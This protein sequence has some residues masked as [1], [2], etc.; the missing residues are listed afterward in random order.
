M[1]NYV[2]KRY[3]EFKLWLGTL[4]NRLTF[5]MIKR[6]YRPFPTFRAYVRYSNDPTHSGRMDM[7]ETYKNGLDS[8]KTPSELRDITRR[9]NKSELT[10]KGRI[11]LFLANVLTK[12]R[13]L[14]QE[15]R[16]Y[17]DKE[18]KKVTVVNQVKEIK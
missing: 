14:Q 9:A 2:K 3:L 13:Q 7:L 15:T 1:T 11:M 5:S 4:R 12:K 6:N 17:K 18:T 10:L 16:I 8:E